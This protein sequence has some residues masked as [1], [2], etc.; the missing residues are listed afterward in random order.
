MELRTLKYFIALVREGN[1]TNAAKALHVT[2]PTL[3]RQLATLEQELGVQLYTRGHKTISLTEQGNVLYRY[4]ESIVGL[5]E[6]CEEEISLPEHTVAGAVHIGVGETKLVAM[7]AQA[8]ERTRR[9]YP[10]IMFE[11]SAGNSADLM[12][13]L[14][15]GR[16]DFLLECEVRPHVNLNVLKLP[17]KDQWGLIVRGDSP[18]AKLDAV[19]PVEFVTTPIIMSQQGVGSAR[20]KDWLGDR[21][22]DLVVSATY[23]LPH[24]GK[25]LVREGLGAMM[26]YGGL[27]DE[28]RSDDLRFV[29]LSPMIESTQGVVWRKVTPSKPAQAFLVELQQLCDE[30]R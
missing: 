23:N 4:A 30:M 8:M 22:D 21:Y 1:I 19:G 14:N 16:Y 12:D 10:N 7:L 9:E 26:T 3:S 24:V 15:K 20:M 17:V 2:Q 28:K 29:P 13:G 18:L 11:L 27:F 6:K 25:F 5:A